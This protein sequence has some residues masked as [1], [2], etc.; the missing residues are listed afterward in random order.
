M[1]RQDLEPCTNAALSQLAGASKSD[2]ERCRWIKIEV[3]LVLAEATGR[4]LGSIGHLEWQDIDLQ[5]KTIRWRADADK[6]GVE[7]VTP[8]TDALVEELREFRQRLGVVGGFLFPGE[9]DPSRPMDRHLFDRWLSEAE[10]AADLPKL[11][12]GLWHPYRR[13]WATERKHH[14][15][16]DVAAAGGWKDHET[17]LRCYQQPD[18]ETMLAVMKEPRKVRDGTVG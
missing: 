2:A 4:R 9:K 15:V 6:R 13:K 12:G 11:D 1:L 7:W 16:K 3:A 8:M 17:I 18:T 10:A 14:S 5:N